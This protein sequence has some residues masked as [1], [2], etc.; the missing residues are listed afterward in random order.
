MRRI[1]AGY[2]PNSFLKQKWVH[3]TGCAVRAIYASCAGT[4]AHRHNNRIMYIC[5]FSCFIKFINELKKRDEMRG[6]PSILSLFRNDFNK[7][8]NTGARML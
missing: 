4:A 6:F 8:H 2:S 5:K 1:R 3:K 7:F